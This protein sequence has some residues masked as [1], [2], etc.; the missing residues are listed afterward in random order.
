[1]LRRFVEHGERLERC[2]LDR[3]G[4]LRGFV[5]AGRLHER[6][7]DRAPPRFVRVLVDLVDVLG[8]VFRRG[9]AV[10]SRGLV[11]VETFPCGELAGRRVADRA[12]RP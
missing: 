12:R 2:H 7:L 5:A 4:T 1:M 9:D 10:L 11:Q 3:V 8:R 6:E